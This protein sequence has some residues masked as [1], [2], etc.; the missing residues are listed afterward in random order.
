DLAQPGDGAVRDADDGALGRLSAAARLDGHGAAGIQRKPSKMTCTRRRRGALLAPP[1]L[2]LERGAPVRLPVP[3][4]DAQ[5]PPPPAGRLLA[6][7]APGQRA[8]DKTQGPSP[9]PFRSPLSR[10][11]LRPKLVSRAWIVE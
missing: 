2:S 5:P 4:P 8:R 11:R 9:V 10:P 6:P 1:P 3:P 7:N